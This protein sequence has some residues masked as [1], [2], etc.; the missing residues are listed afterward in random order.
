MSVLQAQPKGTK[1]HVTYD[2]VQH[3]TASEPTAGKTVASDACPESG[4]KGKELSP[5]DLVGAGLANCMLLS[6]GVL[7]LR[8]HL[9]IT[10]ASVE[11]DISM[12]HK[13]I[14]RIGTIDLTFSMPRNFSSEERLKLERAA[15]MCPI[16]HSFH[17]DIQI[18]VQYN[19]PS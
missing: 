8:D 6:M 4:G 7:A 9:D 16:K 1:L 13:P 15:G 11:V 3:C 5:S 2:G 18:A 14:F 12:T 17:S 19:Y 10:G